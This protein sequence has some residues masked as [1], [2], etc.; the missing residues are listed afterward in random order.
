MQSTYNIIVVVTLAEGEGEKKEEKE[1]EE[2]EVMAV[3]MVATAV[4]GLRSM[5]DSGRYTAL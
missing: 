4:D 3:S 1:V 2:K 5:V